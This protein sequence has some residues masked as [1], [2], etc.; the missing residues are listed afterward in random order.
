MNLW[1]VLIGIGAIALLVYEFRSIRRS[2]VRK[3]VR[4]ALPGFVELY[5]SAIQSGINPTDAFSYLS[6]FQIDGLQ[7]EL[8]ELQSM[9]NRGA[10]FE[11]GL[12]EF[13]NRLAVPEVDR[14]V[15]ILKLSHAAGGQNLVSNLKTLS[16]ELHS[17][18]SSEGAIEARLGAVLIVAKFG[19]LAPWVLV[20]VLSVNSQSR[21]AY[22]SN[23][24]GLL[25]LVG[26]LVSV[27]AYRLV[28]FAGKPFHTARILAGSHG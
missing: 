17:V 21:L 28:M 25:L 4:A 11:Q 26:F 13:R 16:D 1:L 8:R 7:N 5:S 6:E 14:F 10:S 19:L 15:A 2:V 22:L 27:V 20:A 12:N 3:R 24:G 23:S 18:I 9:L